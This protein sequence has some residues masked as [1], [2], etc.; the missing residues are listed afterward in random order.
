MARTWLIS[1]ALFILTRAVSAQE[2][3]PGTEFSVDQFY[4]CSFDYEFASV[5]VVLDGESCPWTATG[6][7]PAARPGCGDTVNVD[8]V[9]YN[10]CPFDGDGDISL[11]PPYSLSAGLRLDNATIDGFAAAGTSSRNLNLINF[12]IAGGAQV[13][14]L[15]SWVDLGHGDATVFIELCPEMEDIRWPLEVGDS[16]TTNLDIHVTA[17]YY[18]N[19]TMF[20]QEYESGSASSASLTMINTVVAQEPMFGCPAVHIRAG[21]TDGPFTMDT[22]Y[23][24]TSGFLSRKVIR[25][26]DIEGFVLDEMIWNVREYNLPQQTPTPVPLTPTPTSGPRT[27]TATPTPVSSATSVI[28]TVTPTPVET[29]APPTP[30]PLPP[31]EFPWIYLDLSATLFRAGDMFLLGMSLTNPNA[32][33]SISTRAA[34]VLDVWGAY[35]SWPSW[36]PLSTELGY[37]EFQLPPATTL[38]QDLLTFRWPEGAGSGSGILLW[39]ALFQH[40]GF[41]TFYNF[42]VTGFSFE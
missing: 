30:T 28:P 5:D 17:Q 6:A 22:W 4:I 7:Q 8:V 1:L 10:G 25:N 23:C 21:Q 29:L 13:R 42:T 37:E 20:G 26:L 19:L 27:P 12:T 34:V 33:A 15:G 31:P 32:A 2:W 18:F 3:I 16:W 39:G 14:L 41:S 9:A 24:L 36:Q 11:P 38:T 35:Y 40:G